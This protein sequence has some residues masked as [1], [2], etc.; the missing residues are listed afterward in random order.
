MSEPVYCRVEIGHGMSD[1][2]QL[3]FALEQCMNL[4]ANIDVNS[5]ARAAEW[6]C[7][8]YLPVKLVD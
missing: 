3:M 5:K 2:L 6:L 1:E 8:K 7:N 4:I